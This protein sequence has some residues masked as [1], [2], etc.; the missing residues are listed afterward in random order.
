MQYLG[1]RRRGQTHK[2]ST[3]TS[4]EP[5][6][7]VAAKNVPPY[8][9]QPHPDAAL[10]N[11]PSLLGGAP[12]DDTAKA[13]VVHRDSE[14]STKL[15]SDAA[16]GLS[17]PREEKEDNLSEAQIPRSWEK[18]KDIVLRPSV[19]GGLV[20]I[21][22]IGLLA[23][24]SYAFY[25]NPRLRRDTKAIMSTIAATFALFG[26]ESYAAEARQ[27]KPE[28]KAAKRKAREE[29]SAYRRIIGHVLRSGGLSGLVG[30]LNVGVL[31]VVSYFAYTN[32]Q[33]PRWDR[34]VVSATSAGLIAL[35]GTEIALFSGDN[36]RQYFY[37]K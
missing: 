22:N 27:S 24:A 34:R 23:G 36:A 26:A 12:F 2:V 33:R 4:M 6:A 9:Q 10:L 15:T 7:K 1:L 13:N 20:G 37:P 19:A 18:V 14:F 32:W 21:A 29:G 3:T 17:P 8:E 5:Y 25:T 30:L 16:S 35:W 31:G 11:T 28:R